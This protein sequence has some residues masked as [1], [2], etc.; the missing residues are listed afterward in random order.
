MVE[1]SLSLHKLYPLCCIVPFCVSFFIETVLRS[2]CHQCRFY[3]GVRSRKKKLFYSWK[4]TCGKYRL[5]RI[6]MTVVFLNVIIQ[7]YARSWRFSPRAVCVGKRNCR[8]IGILGTIAKETRMLF[9][10]NDKR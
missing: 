3:T 9:C 10:C 6:C 5:K 7:Y 4:E 8:A 2:V 1:Y